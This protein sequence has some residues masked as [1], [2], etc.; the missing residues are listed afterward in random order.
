MRVFK[1][2]RF[3]DF[4]YEHPGVKYDDYFNNL[5]EYII[6]YFSELTKEC[7]KVNQH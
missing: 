6:K 1:P 3:R 2:P 4:Q 7:E 5:A